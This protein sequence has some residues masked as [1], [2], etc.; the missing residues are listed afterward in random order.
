VRFAS[1]SAAS[2]EVPFELALPL[3]YRNDLGKI[4]LDLTGSAKLNANSG[5]PTAFD[6]SG[7]LN[8]TG[9]PQGTQL[10]LSGRAKLSGTLSYP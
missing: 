1:R 7:P 6:L 3:Q 10:S 2:A 9:G 8:A 4:E 5:R